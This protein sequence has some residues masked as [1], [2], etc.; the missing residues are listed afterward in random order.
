MKSL[1][2]E[3][4]ELL[5]LWIAL[6]VLAV[7]LVLFAIIFF[8]WWIAT[9]N[10]LRREQVKIDEAASGID[11]AL[12]KRFDLLTKEVAVVKGYAKHESETLANVIGMRRPA[13]GATMKE[14]AEFSQEVSKAF[15]SINVV[16]EQY[17]DLKAN[18]NFMALQNE[19][20]DV[21]EQLQASRRVYN[22]NVSLYNQEIIVFPASIVAR[23]YGFAKR[24][25]FEAEEVKRQDVK[26]EF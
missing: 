23:H 18:A 14:K 13:S 12:T 25:F 22:S 6:I 24:D 16:C 11:V 9:A 7:L 19:I 15:D 26:I 17:P 10:R 8:S 3:G 4:N 1:F 2:L 5:P 21:E 20:A